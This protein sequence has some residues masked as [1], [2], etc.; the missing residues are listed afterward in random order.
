[1]L[2]LPDNNFTLIEPLHNGHYLYSITLTEPTSL[3]PGHKLQINDQ[4]LHV[5]NHQDKKLQLICQQNLNLE[6]VSG[7]KAEVIGQ[8]ISDEQINALK[9][10][11]RLIISGRNDGIYHALFLVNRMR[12]LL[13]ESQTRELIELVV[14]ESLETFPFRPEPSQFITDALPH[15]VIGTIPLL[16]DLKICCRLA[17]PHGMPGCFEG[18]IEELLQHLEAEPH[19]VHFEG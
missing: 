11:G 4:A 2:Q 13:G 9:D 1:M 7:K 16:E 5:L 18:T 15:G 14:F 12:Q 8:G 19:R 17:Q 6:D 3:S 10:E